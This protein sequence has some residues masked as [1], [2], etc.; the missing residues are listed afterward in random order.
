MEPRPEFCA[1][2]EHE[3]LDVDFFFLI[4]RPSE[5]KAETCGGKFL[6][7]V[8]VEEIRFFVRIAEEEPVAARCVGG[9]AFFEEGAERGN[10]C[11]GADHDHVRCAVAGEAESWIVVDENTGFMAVDAIRE[12]GRADAA[13]FAPVRLVADDADAEMN[14]AWVSFWAGGDGV[15]ARLE[16]FQHRDKFVRVGEIGGVIDDEIDEIAAPAE[17]IP[18]VA[19]VGLDERAEEGRAAA[20]L[21]FLHERFVERADVEVLKEG[22]AEGNFSIVGEG[23]RAG[24]EWEMLENFI[25]DGFVVA[26]VHAEGVADFVL[27]LRVSERKG[28][29]MGLFVAALVEIE[30]RENFGGIRILLGEARFGIEVGCTCFCGSCRGG[31]CRE[32]RIAPEFEWLVEIDIDIDAWGDACGAEFG[33]AFIE[34]DAAFAEVWVAGIAEGEDGVGDTVEARG[35]IG[36]DGVVKIGCVVGWFSVAVGGSN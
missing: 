9:L 26:W 8:A 36:K 19:V 5:V 14:F 11:A 12:E 6:E 29:V 22:V 30:I 16:F 27:E 15:E 25:D 23:D 24:F 3:V 10:A 28:E 32:N 21:P 35:G 17:L 13:A 20:G 34:D 31:E 18:H 7:F 4:A 33:E 2:L 1:L